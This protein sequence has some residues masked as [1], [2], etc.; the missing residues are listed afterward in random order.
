MESRF[1]EI[2]KI[3]KE[4]KS[5]IMEAFDVRRKEKGE[6]QF[7]KSNL[8]NKYIEEILRDYA[9]ANGIDFA[10]V[11]IEAKQKYDEQLEYMKKSDI[12][13]GTVKQNLAEQIAFEYVIPKGLF[14]KKEFLEMLDWVVAKHKVLFLLRDP[15]SNKIVS[16][17]YYFV[18][19]PKF[20][21]VPQYMESVDTAA[22][23][24]K[25]ELIF[26]TQFADKLCTFYWYKQQYKGI[27]P[28]G[29]MYQSNGGPI[30][31]YYA[32]LEFV[33]LHEFLHIVH[34]DH[35]YSKEL[36]TDPVIQNYVGDF[37]INYKLVKSGYAQLPIGLFSDEINF[38]RQE[39]EEEMRDIIIREL[40]KL[41]DEEK[42]KATENMNNAMDDHFDN[43][44][45]QTND[46]GAKPNLDQ[47]QQSQ[48]DQNQQGQNG[49]QSQDNQDG[50]RQAQS[51]QQDQVQSDQGS[52]G[53][54]DSQE[55]T[56]QQGQDLE[57]KRKDI[58]E[59]LDDILNQAK[60]EEKNLN[61]D[62]VK[63]KAAEAKNRT[64]VD[65]DGEQQSTLDDI[66]N[67]AKSRS[68]DSSIDLDTSFNPTF[69]WKKLLQMMV[70]TTQ[71]EI[72]TYSKPSRRGASRL[73]M[74]KQ[75]GAAAIKP[76][77]KK[78]EGDK[79][80]LVLV[81]DNSGSVSNALGKVMATFLKLL[82]NF[83]KSID[84][85]IIIRF[86]D[87]YD[88]F[89]GDLKTKSIKKVSPDSLPKLLQS[90]FK[91]SDIKL[92]ESQKWTFKKF[93]S[94]TIGFGAGTE[95]SENLLKTII[96]LWKKDMNV[97]L[98]TDT[99]IL[100]RKNKENLKKL[101]KTTKKRQKSFS[102]ILTTKYDYERV[103]EEIGQSKFYTYIEK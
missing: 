41:N 31:D 63:Q 37:V 66:L 61:Q 78:E 98:F 21:K 43:Q 45:E 23:T 1:N 32:Y 97:I 91:M 74:L 2:L 33:V 54:Q 9:K 30:P 19:A 88:V 75:K 86:D 12:L 57:Q 65:N 47:N 92:K 55:Q 16:F 60:E 95:F 25:G 42:Q 69:S 93:F 82:E 90:S 71:E 72:E 34:A 29:K 18:P 28:N 62:N 10:E 77:E 14:K 83:K 3:V 24:A 52:Q 84:N 58:N 39:T 8:G 49:Q 36:G 53:E 101:I 96:N 103:C 85:I 59:K 94:D 50:Q 79:K 27:K 67:K 4:Q 102:M 5:P 70:P 46:S 48:Q 7:E 40:N 81:I 38:D 99:D 68:S 80:S 100:W 51:D 76:G 22:T 89:V 17:S 15:Y 56:N 35:F 6:V 44:N 64:E 20:A 13:F 11:F 73:S 26:N 87:T